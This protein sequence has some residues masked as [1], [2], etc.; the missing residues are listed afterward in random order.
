MVLRGTFFSVVSKDEVIEKL[1]KLNE[2]YDSANMSYGHQRVSFLK[3]YCHGFLDVIDS[4]FAVDLRAVKRCRASV[5]KYLRVDD[6]YLAMIALSD[7]R[8]TSANLLTMVKE[9]IPLDDFPTCKSILDLSVEDALSVANDLSKNTF[10]KVV[11][12]AGL[13]GKKI[14]DVITISDVKSFY[15]DQISRLESEIA[16]DRDRPSPTEELLLDKFKAELG[17]CRKAM[18]KTG[19]GV[20]KDIIG[21]ISTADEAI[22]RYE[23]RCSSKELHTG[24]ARLQDRQ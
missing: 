5:E 4:C 21:L 14:G 16:A 13:L 22:K 2:R 6:P 8:D 11:I 9:F 24:P 19:I 10:T 23:E 15:Q 17:Y 20:T 18:V 3:A 1:N 7:V 12:G